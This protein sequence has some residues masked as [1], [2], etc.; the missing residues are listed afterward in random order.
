[1][2]NK[3]SNFFWI[4][5]QNLENNDRKYLKLLKLRSQIK[6]NP[7]TKDQK[8]NTIFKNLDFQKIEK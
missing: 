1:M 6:K 7:N 5:N 2:E 4:K 8:E 3:I